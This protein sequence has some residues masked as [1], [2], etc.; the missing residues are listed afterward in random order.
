[1]TLTDSSTVI[2]NARFFSYASFVLIGTINTFL[3]PILPFLSEKWAINDQQSGYFLAVQSLGGMIGTLAVAFLYE[4]LSSRKILL[5]GF[6]LIIVSLFGIGGGDWKIGFFSSL[7][8]GI[9]IG[10]II[11]TTTLIVSQTAGNKRAGAINLLNFFWAFGAVLSPLIFLRLSSAVQLN[12]LLVLIAL[13]GAV[14]FGLLF[15]QKEFRLVAE[16]HESHSSCGK[17]LN[18]FA[19]NWIF[20]V[21][22]FLQIGVEAS[23]SGWLPSY[24]KRFTDSEIWLIV[25]LVYWTGFLLSRLLSSIFLESISE[26]KLIINGL[27][28]VTAGLILVISNENLALISIGALF[29]GFGTAPVFPTTIALASAKFENNA[30]ELINY[31]FFLAGLSGMFFLWLIGFVSSITDDL[32]T[33]FWIPIVC[34]LILLI[35]CWLKFYLDKE[36]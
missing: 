11:P 24:A 14:F 4:R 21:I 25:P 13:I 35:V 15:K 3:G 17:K 31:L 5:A 7:I 1:M 27:I 6:G 28:L 34:S 33:A 16:K 20:A 29:T 10:F 30:P 32:K 18:I 12:Y 2:K 8:S 26:T 23:L 22:I 19:A 9:G 36:S